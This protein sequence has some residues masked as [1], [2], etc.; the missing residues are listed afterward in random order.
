[1][2]RRE[3]LVQSLASAALGLVPS[4]IL[5]QIAVQP[6]ELHTRLEHSYA[7]QY[8][9]M[10][11]SN[12]TERLNALAAKWDEVRAKIH[13]PQD[14]EARAQYVRKTALE[15]IGGLPERTPLNPVITRVLERDGYRI[16]NVRYES[17]PN[18][19]VTGNLYVPTTGKGPFP[20][21]LS[22][23]G[24]YEDAGRSPAYQRAHLDFV[25]S[26]FVVLAP[27]PI[28]Q[29]ERRLYWDTTTQTYLGSTIDEHSMFAQLMWLLGDSLMQYFAW[30]VSRGIDYL[31]GRPEVDGSKIGCSG[32]SGG[33]FQ[34]VLLMLYDQRVKCAACIEPGA[35][36]YWPLHIPPGDPINP[37]DGEENWFPAATKGL[38]FCDF[39]KSF[40][41][42]PLLLAV[43]T[44]TN[45][46]F[47][48]AVASI[49]KH[50]ELYGAKD[51][52]QTVE[53]TDAHYWTLKLRLAA[54]DWFCHWFYDHPG[55]AQEPDVAVEPV[56]D[57]FC[58][59]TGS[60]SD[61]GLGDSVRSII[62]RQQQSLPPKH[63]PPK[64]R[65][66][67]AS[68]RQEMQ[69]SLRKLLRITPV[70]Q[71]LDVC[72][73][74]TTPRTGFSIEKVEFM[75]EPGIYVPAWVFLPEHPVKEARPILYIGDID[76]ETVGYPESG[77]GGE[78]A[79]MGHMVIAVDVRGMGQT[80]PLH[81]SYFDNGTWS[82]LF[83]AETAMAYMAWSMDSSL[84]GMRVS[85]V[86]RSVDYALSRPE[87]DRSR[88]VVIGSG[89]GALWGLYAAVLDPRIPFLIANGGLLSYKVL[90]QSDRYKV[91]ANI[92][93]PGV[94]KQLDL[95]Q[96]AAA[97]ADRRLVLISPTG[98]MKTPVPLD[99][100]RQAYRF[101]GN[102][103]ENLGVKEQFQIVTNDPVLGPAAQYHALLNEPIRG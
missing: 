13:S 47:E 1:M 34:T 14:A 97:L 43:E 24:H 6:V 50:Y 103:Y 63:Q 81:H 12:L 61:A 3:L 85:D 32:H 26:G 17:R 70:A 16:E 46:G 19:W 7:E 37:G 74:A 65:A 86:M 78:L 58:T 100:V 2:N 22:P 62:L 93:V 31:V 11:V 64:S 67:L 92:M 72:R 87:L 29:G 56:E 75:S 73:L 89:M 39:Y 35:Y 27:D 44:Y 15:M 101:A 57:L 96:A 53:S 71:S 25:K 23:S 83:D 79:Q 49:Q 88:L 60:L 41:P 59:P 30:D 51:K 10:L 18:F 55:P 91:G 95:P 5:S 40:A 20:A 102:A 98:P 90:V 21:I 54:T 94:L 80:R 36:Q 66:E 33:G 45:A 38:D 69:D 68:Y 99:D 48:T 76:T 42:R 84:L 4:K 9:D 77:W 28:G 82:N 52:F 8:P